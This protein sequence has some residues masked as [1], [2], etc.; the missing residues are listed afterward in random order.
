[1][2]TVGVHSPISRWSAA[3]I[4]SELE[5]TIQAPYSHDF[6]EDIRRTQDGDLDAIVAPYLIARAG[7]RPIALLAEQAAGTLTT[8]KDQGVDVTASFD[9]LLV[10]PVGLEQSAY[11]A[12][13]RDTSIILEVDS[14]FSHTIS[15]LGL[16]PQYVDG[17]DYADLV[18]SQL[19]ALFELQNTFC[20]TC[21]CGEDDCRSDCP[22]C[23]G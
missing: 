1:M 23:D 13:S 17:S 22:K 3:K 6:G 2:V 18:L 19:S 5:V 4:F 15:E 8:A 7:L 12:I 10:A 20:D 11:E 9:Y 21:D 16:R 14:I